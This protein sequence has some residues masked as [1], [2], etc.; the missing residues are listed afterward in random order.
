MDAQRQQE[1]ED[2]LRR[3]FEDAMCDPLFLQ[4]VEGTMRDFEHID[5]ETAR[6]L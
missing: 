3:E 4:D 2:M 1:R 5:I 6:M